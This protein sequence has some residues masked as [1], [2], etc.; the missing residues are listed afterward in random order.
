M[1]DQKLDKTTDQKPKTRLEIQAPNGL[2]YPASRVNGSIKGM[3]TRIVRVLPVEAVGLY[4]PA[5]GAT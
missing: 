5:D 2:W 1:S 3:N 4:V